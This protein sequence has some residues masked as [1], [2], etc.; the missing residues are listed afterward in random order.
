MNNSSEGKHKDFDDG[1]NA[2]W[3][4][5]GKEAQAHDEALFKGILAEMDGVPT[6]AALFA[7]V[8]T[9]FLVEGLKN[10]QADPA[11]QSVYYQEQSVAILAQISRQIASIAPNVSISPTPNLTS[12]SPYQ[13]FPPLPLDVMVNSYWIAGLIFSLSAALFATLVQEWVRSY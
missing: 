3:S 5:Y 7:A 6:F 13:V 4:L 1:A 10:L 9:S 11:K 12:P 2:L 8:I